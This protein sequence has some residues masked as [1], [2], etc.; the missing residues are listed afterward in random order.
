MGQEQCMVIL[1]EEAHWPGQENEM[2][3]HQRLFSEGINAEIS[4]RGHEEFIGY[5]G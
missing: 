5:W 3:T 2:V 4:S 1:T